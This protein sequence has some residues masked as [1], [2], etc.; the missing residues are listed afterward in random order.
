M[1]APDPAEVLPVIADLAA[2]SPVSEERR[3]C[4]SCD[5]LIEHHQPN[6][7]WYAV[8]VGRRDADLVCPCS[9]PADQAGQECVR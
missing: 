3:R 7:C 2:Q 6:G 5:H 4:P 9:M 8:S 1:S